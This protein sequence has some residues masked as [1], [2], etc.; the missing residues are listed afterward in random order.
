MVIAS[1]GGLLPL[2]PLCYI[3]WWLP[4]WVGSCLSYLSA[5]YYGDCQSGWGP[6]SWWGISFS[7]LLSHL[8]LLPCWI[9]TKLLCLRTTE[10][11]PSPPMQMLPPMHTGFISTTHYNTHSTYWDCP[12]RSSIDSHIIWFN[13]DHSLHTSFAHTQK[14]TNKLFNLF[15]MKPHFILRQITV[16]DYDPYFVHVYFEAKPLDELC[17]GEHLVSPRLAETPMQYI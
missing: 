16:R 11:Y 3:I 4:V 9:L 17:W 13:P 15:N 1:L 14:D 5:A 2:L 6:L 10:V 8:S 12:T 7:A